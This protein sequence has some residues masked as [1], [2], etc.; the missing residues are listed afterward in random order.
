MLIQQS[1]YGLGE[2]FDIGASHNDIKPDN[3]FFS[4]NEDKSLN[5]KIGDFG[6]LCFEKQTKVEYYL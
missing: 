1:F 4:L 2:I 5:L 3:I 6:L